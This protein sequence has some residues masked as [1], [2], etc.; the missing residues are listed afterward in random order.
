M[1]WQLD[2]FVASLDQSSSILL[3]ILRLA[4]HAP[5]GQAVRIRRQFVLFVKA[6]GPK[7]RALRVQT[8]AP[9]CHGCSPSAELDVVLDHLEVAQRELRP[10]LKRSER[11]SAANG[12]SMS[13]ETASYV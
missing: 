4:V 6:L 12:N 5:R 8:C 2:A 11:Q 9:L 1:R 7:S 13:G 10:I 3:P